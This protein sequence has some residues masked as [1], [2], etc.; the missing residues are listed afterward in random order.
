MKKL[1]MGEITKIKSLMKRRQ[2]RRILLDISWG[3]F[4]SRQVF[5][6]LPF[7]CTN[8]CP[9]LLK[10][11]HERF[12]HWIRFPNGWRTFTLI[13]ENNLSIFCFNIL[14]VNAFLP[15]NF[16]CKCLYQIVD[17]FSII[18]LAFYNLGMNFGLS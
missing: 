15:L 3:F 9:T 10:I 17:S 16:V 4:L 11:I 13:H 18:C 7:L 5:L 6:S 2:K 1:L 14:S 8:S 12:L